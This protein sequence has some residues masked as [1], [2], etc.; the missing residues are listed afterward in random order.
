MAMIDPCTNFTPNGPNCPAL[1][2][3]ASYDYNLKTPIG[4]NDAISAPLCKNT[5]KHDKPVATWKAGQT[6]SASFEGGG[7]AHGGGHCQFSLSYD[8]G[9]TFVVVYEHLRYCFFDG[10]SSSNTASVLNYKFTLPESVPA[11]NSVVFAWSWVNAVGNREF[12]MNC[13]DVAIT[14]NSNSFS[15]KQMVIANYG[16][17]NPVIP[18][19][20]GNHET[21]IDLYN[22]SP[23]ITVYGNGDTSKNDNNGQNSPSL[24]VTMVDVSSDDDLDSEYDSLFG[25]DDEDDFSDD[26]GKAGVIAPVPVE[27]NNE[28]VITPT[29]NINNNDN[30]V[31]GATP[32]SAVPPPNNNNNDNTVNGGAPDNAVPPPNNNNSND[33]ASDNGGPQG[34]C[35]SGNMK[36]GPDGSNSFYK[37]NNQEW[38]KFNNPPGVSCADDGSYISFSYL[39]RK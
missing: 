27:N 3:G 23:V 37:C 26:G 21:G 8:G 15:G 28:S 14:S 13:A 11:S 25:S 19:F 1:P 31:Y 38:V 5:G 35:T 39:K 32:E 33:G 30:T 6:V 24:P 16:P 12:Y 2:A 22:N 7:A 20:N 18:E 4:T 29:P 10:P 9:K 36:C 17:G 34:S